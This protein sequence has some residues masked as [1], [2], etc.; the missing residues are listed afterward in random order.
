MKIPGLA[1]EKER[2]KVKNNMMTQNLCKRILARSIGSAYDTFGH[3][4]SWAILA[5][6]S[7]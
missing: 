1:T 2:M 4:D 5:V 6:S 7:F 3:I